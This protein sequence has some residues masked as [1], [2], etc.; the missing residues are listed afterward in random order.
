MERDQDQRKIT[1]IAIKKID[2]V[3]REIDQ[4]PILVRV[5]IKTRKEGIKN[6]DCG[7]NL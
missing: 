3:K 7:I 4:D 1:T 2:Q 6:D 5:R